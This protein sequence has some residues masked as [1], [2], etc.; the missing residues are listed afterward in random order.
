MTTEYQLIPDRVVWNGPEGSEVVMD[1][2]G[3]RLLVPKWLE[4]PDLAVLLQIIARAKQLRDTGGPLV[5]RPPTN[6][7]LKKWEWRAH[8]KLAAPAI[9]EKI[10]P[11]DD[12]I[13]VEIVP[14]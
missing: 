14:F 5:P 6:D 3:I 2:D 7:E 12:L 1:E 4:Q 9:I 8:E 11:D 13:D 10:A